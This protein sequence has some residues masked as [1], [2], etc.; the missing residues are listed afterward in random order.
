MN[1]SPGNGGLAG[2]ARAVSFAALW[3]ACAMLA[4][5]ILVLNHMIVIRLLGEAIVW[6]L[7]MSI[8]LT[9]GAFFLAT[10]YAVLSK[11][12]VAIDLLSAMLSSRYAEI[13]RVAVL[14]VMLLT[15]AYLV[16]SGLGRTLEALHS[17]LRS[18]SLWGPLLWPVYAAMPLGLAL[19]CL[20]IV[21][22]LSSS[23]AR[24]RPG[25]KS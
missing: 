15:A 22:E 12:D 11:G 7:E 23:I 13:M 19:A 9:I 25:K 24:L 14:I 5:V 3:V 4:A 10:P 1:S 17:N 8:Y 18:T 16:W 2:L 20:Q 6:H 21:A